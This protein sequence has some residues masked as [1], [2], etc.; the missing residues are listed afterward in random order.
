MESASRRTTSTILSVFMPDMVKGVTLS[1]H[2][3]LEE[4][5]GNGV[6]GH[7][8]RGGQGRGGG[9]GESEIRGGG[10][11]TR[12]EEDR[13]SER[14]EG[15]GR[16]G[17]ERGRHYYEEEEE[18]HG[19]DGMVRRE[20]GRVRIGMNGVMKERV[21]ACVDRIRGVMSMMKDVYGEVRCVGDGEDV[22]RR[23]VGERWC[24]RD[25]GEGRDEVMAMVASEVVR[26]C[27]EKLFLG[28]ARGTMLQIDVHLPVTVMEE[29]EK[30]REEDPREMCV[31]GVIDAAR[32]F[33]L[34]MHDEVR[35]RRCTYIHTLEN[36]NVTVF[37]SAIDAN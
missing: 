20:G 17:G 31:R 19:G 33:A 1:I 35:R 32:C 16:G 18:E 28:N 24:F 4:H 29:E 11:P 30:E 15:G 25:D 23:F 5:N 36:H 26:G 14:E 21:R 6:R 34:A 10:T 27:G 12:D 3:D 22:E 2:V 37:Q 9:R 13:R 8:G 7:G